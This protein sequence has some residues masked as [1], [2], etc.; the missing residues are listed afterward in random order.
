MKERAV[1]SAAKPSTP[2][3]A[4]KDSNV[5]YVYGVKMD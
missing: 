1:H 2:A 3:T 5:G 4:I